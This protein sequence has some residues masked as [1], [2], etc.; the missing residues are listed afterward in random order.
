MS[1]RV[2]AKI[3]EELYNQILAAGLKPSDFDLLDGFIPR[4]R[5]NEVSDKFKTSNEKILTYEQ[6]LAETKKLLDESTEYK[7]KYSELET[8]YSTDLA[9]K[10]KELSNISKRFLVEQHLTKQGAKHTKLLMK[11]I[12]LD[13]LTIEGEN[14]LGLDKTIKDLKTN[15]QDLFTT[16]SV[17]GNKETNTSSHNSGSKD[18]VGEDGINW[19]EKLSHL[20]T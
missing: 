8:K 5:F 4:T 14:V 3:G 11:E 17:V 15:Y 10:D 9:N 1:D 13:G 18:E 6:Q 7:S 19:G 2:K 16:K 12:D 20:K